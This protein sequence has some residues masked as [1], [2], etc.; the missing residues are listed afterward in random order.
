MS[1]S[2]DHK[3]TENTGHTNK[4]R[5]KDRMNLINLSL[6]M[7]SKTRQLYTQARIQIRKYLC[8]TVLIII[9]I[10]DKSLPERT[11]RVD[12]SDKPWITGYIKMQI[13]AREKAFSCSDKLRYKQLC[14]KVANLI[15]TAKANYYR[16]KASEF[17]PSNQ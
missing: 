12:H 13:K 3:K 2:Q 16:S 6:K 7:P 15:V 14:E 9:K 10:H 5:L 17:R 1:P 4:V 11:V 8:I